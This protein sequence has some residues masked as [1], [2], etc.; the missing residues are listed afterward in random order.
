MADHDD[1]R[2]SL[3]EYHSLRE[4]EMKQWE[5]P[6]FR[7]PVEKHGETR[8]KIAALLNGLK[9]L[10]PEPEALAASKSIFEELCRTYRESDDFERTLIR[11]MIDYKPS[12]AFVGYSE[13]AAVEAIRSKRTV[14]IQNALI[15]HVIENL[16]WG[17]VRDNLVRLG[18][19]Y[20]CARAIDP[21]PADF[22]LDAAK[23]AGPAM[24]AVLADFV[25]RPDLDEILSA[26]GWEEVAT[27]DGPEFR[28]C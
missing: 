12:A 7:E 9:G 5:Q 10:A 22:F 24:S 1:R 11:S 21:N 4:E 26:M 25:R 13:L 28:W 17:D 6:G 19:V 3:D 14:A 8:T 2:R 20:H 27:P 16:A 23:I 18:L 15:A